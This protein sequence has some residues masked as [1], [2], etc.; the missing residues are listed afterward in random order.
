MIHLRRISQLFFLFLFIIFLLLIFNRGLS[1]ISHLVSF[2]FYSD[3]LH[4][5]SITLPFYKNVTEINLLWFLSIIFLLAAIFLGRY[6]CGWVCPFGTLLHIHSKIYSKLYKF[7][8]VPDLIK[9]N[10]KYYILVFLIFFIL[11]GFN[12]SS[13]LDPISILFKTITFLLFPIIY[14]ISLLFTNLMIKVFGFS[15]FTLFIDN[16]LKNNLIPINQPFYQTFWLT[17]LIFIIIFYLNKYH[18]RFWCKYLCP[19][20]AFYGLI[21]NFSFFKRSIKSSFTNF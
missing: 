15:D 18:F 2:F 14:L 19:L 11:F 8:K 9:K 16:W 4:L 7:K 10:L 20:G 1:Y 13:Y 5:I 17:L 21:A 3:P 6:F 12:L